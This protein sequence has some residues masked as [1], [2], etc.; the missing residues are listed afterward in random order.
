[1]T[2]ALKN[3]PAMQGTTPEKSWHTLA[4]AVGEFISSSPSP[5]F[6][7]VYRDEVF[8]ACLQH[9]LGEGAAYS[10]DAIRYCS[11]NLVS[12]SLCHLIQ[13]C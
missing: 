4:I 5:Q 7:D 13:V 10:S 6:N 11:Q 12:V 2:L 9:C 3:Q 1:M 8:I